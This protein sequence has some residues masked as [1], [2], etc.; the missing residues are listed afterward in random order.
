MDN[1]NNYICFNN[2][3]DIIFIIKEFKEIIEWIE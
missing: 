2:W 1:L 3:N